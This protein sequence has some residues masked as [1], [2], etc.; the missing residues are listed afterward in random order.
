LR[1]V[2]TGAIKQG[3][4][5]LWF[6][7]AIAILGLAIITFASYLLKTDAKLGLIMG[8]GLLLVYILFP[9]LVMPVFQ[10]QWKRFAH[11]H[12]YF[13]NAKFGFTATVKQYIKAYVACLFAY[14]GFLIILGLCFALGLAGV[15]GMKH[16]AGVKDGFTRYLPFILIGL[17]CFY[18][19]LFT[20]V[21]YI[22]A[23][24]F[25]LAWN[26]TQIASHKFRAA[27][28]VWGMVKLAAGNL[29][30]ILLTLGFFRPFAVIRTQRYLLE[31]LFLDLDA[32]DTDVFKSLSQ[33]N[34][35]AYA[36][37]ALDL[38]GDMDM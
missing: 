29:L 18:A 26:N 19:L 6:P 15:L 1:F 9:I 33:T 36:E 13:G 38:F 8:L 32:S 11:E 2:F 34:P 10:V 16:E 20:V 22:R 31:H 14:A 21:P 28:P 37:G 24:F 30:F 3:Y 23:L 17:A 27:L 5:T 35:R 25:N 7:L 12:S 4:L